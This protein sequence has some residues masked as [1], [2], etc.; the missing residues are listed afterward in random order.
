MESAKQITIN[1]FKSLGFTAEAIPEST[2]PR[3]GIRAN[4]GKHEY[5]IEVKTK[6]DDPKT[7]AKQLTAI[8]TEDAQLVMRIS[9][10]DYSNR[11]DAIFKF[12]GKQLKE[13]PADSTPFRLIWLHCAG[14]D[15]DLLEVRARNTFYGIVPVVPVGSGN[16][17]MCFY[18][19][20]NTAFMLPHVNGLLIVVRDGLRLYV[21]EFASSVE[22]FRNSR[23]FDELRPAIFDPTEIV[24]N[25]VHIALNSDISR[26]DENA[27][28]N[29]LEKQTGVRYRTARMNRH[30]FGAEVG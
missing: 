22:S 16:G 19:D 11:V 14:M 17:C 15:N 23:L 6:I 13:T 8:D 29:A 21:N 3:A 7:L 9:P 2:E 5:I 26:G 27:V 18:F 4:D 25:E 24:A 10:L 12:C 28:L 1:F 30:S 20:F